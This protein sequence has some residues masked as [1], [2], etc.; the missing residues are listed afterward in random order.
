MLTKLKS[1]FSR[2]TKTTGAT[3][4]EVAAKPVKDASYRV[5]L[6]GEGPVIL[7]AANQTE[8]RAFVREAHGLKRLPA[9]TTVERL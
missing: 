2:K 8:V 9:G 5:Q 6:P 3:T 1:K 4:T 7:R